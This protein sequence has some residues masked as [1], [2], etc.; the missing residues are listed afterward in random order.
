MTDPDLEAAYALRTP[1][2]SRR[3]YADWANDYDMTFAAQEDYELHLH[4]ARAFAQAGGKGPV[5]DV[6]AGTGLCGLALAGHRMKPV[7][8]VDISPEMLDVAMKKGVYRK[9]YEAD[10]TVGLPMEDESYEGIVSS[11]TFTTGHVGPDAIDALLP[12]ACKGAVFALSVNKK[13]YVSEGF[14]AK[15]A[16]L[17]KGAIE[18]LELIETKIFGAK[19]TGAHKEDTAL[20][21]VFRKA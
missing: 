20:I 7:D 4:T 15:F 2:D 14:E 16:E 5:L 3:L 1:D 18:G 12:V 19:A 11:G 9:S 10:L 21:A 17:S 6:G 13:H 8:A